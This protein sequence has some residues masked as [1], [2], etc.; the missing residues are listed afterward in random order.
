MLTNCANKDEDSASR[1]NRLQYSSSG[2]LE[3]EDEYCKRLVLEAESSSLF[4]Q[5]VSI[6][7][8]FK[9]SEARDAGLLAG[10]RGSRHAVSLASVF[11][12]EAADHYL[13]ANARAI[14]KIRVRPKDRPA[15]SNH[16]CK[17][18]AP[19]PL[20]PAPIAIASRPIAIGMFASVEAR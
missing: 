6:Q 16:S 11:L 14:S 4:A 9:D 1:T 7:A 15:G 18:C 13:R 19:P 20:P 3:Q 2:S 12:A 10:F 5:F 8:N 17:V